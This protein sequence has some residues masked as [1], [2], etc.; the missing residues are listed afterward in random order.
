MN[1]IGAFEAKTHIS[2]LPGRVEAAEELVNARHGRPVSHLVPG[3]DAR[4]QGATMAV[5]RLRE[6]RR[7]IT[8]EG[9]DWRER[10][11]ADEH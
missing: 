2:E 3:T 10:R 9:I 4:D 8:L 7:G 1:H 5:K 11:D 6:L